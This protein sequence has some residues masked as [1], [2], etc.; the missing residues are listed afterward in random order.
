MDADLMEM[1][2]TILGVVAGVV[3][4]AP[5]VARQAWK[6]RMP[7]RLVARV[8]GALA[9]GM[10]HRLKSETQAVTGKY[11]LTYDQE[12]VVRNEAVVAVRQA[13]ERVDA[14][15]P[16]VLKPVLPSVSEAL[17][18]AEYEG[19]LRPLIERE[20]RKRKAKVGSRLKGA[21]RK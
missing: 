15:V 10:V 4:A 1:I 6:W 17:A 14:A 2:W 12:K 9:D 16:K 19:K 13:A 3:S 11:D 7:I 5:W 18:E 20:V 21:G 8:V